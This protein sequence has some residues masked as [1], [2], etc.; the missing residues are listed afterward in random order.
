MA[1][2]SYGSA[3]EPKTDGRGGPPLL[4]TIQSEVLSQLP[5]ERLALCSVD[6][7]GVRRRAVQ[8]VAVVSRIDVDVKVPHVLTPGWLVVLT[9]RD[10]IASV[11]LT[12]RYGNDLREIVNSVAV[13]RGQTVEILVV[14]G[15]DDEHMAVIVWPPARRDE[16]DRVIGPGDNVIVTGDP[17]VAGSHQLAERAGVVRWLVRVHT[18]IVSDIISVPPDR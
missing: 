18:L 1:R 2:S 16:G 9:C 4:A 3:S 5:R 11:C 14:F 13:S 7:I 17:G 10:P 6:E 12:H 8:V 15:R